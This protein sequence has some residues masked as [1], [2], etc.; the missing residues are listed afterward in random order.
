MRSARI[1]AELLS[2]KNQGFFNELRDD[3]S[4]SLRFYV[5]RFI[6]QIPFLTRVLPKFL[7]K[8]SFIPEN[9]IHL[10]GDKS[11]NRM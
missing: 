7:L 3:A 4:S 10:H 6:S 1:S 5:A 9:T 11:I 8:K 2:L